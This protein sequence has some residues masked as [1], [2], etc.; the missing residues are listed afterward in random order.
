MN[1]YLITYA[2]STNIYKELSMKFEADSAEHAIEQL[3]DF[4]KDMV[5]KPYVLLIENYSRATY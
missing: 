4:Y 5:E 2:E 1:T 3:E